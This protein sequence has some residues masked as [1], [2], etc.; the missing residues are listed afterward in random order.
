M[1]RL[2]GWPFNVALWQGQAPCLPA[3]TAAEPGHNGSM[4]ELAVQCA[5]FKDDTFQL[6]PKLKLKSLATFV[7]RGQNRR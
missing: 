7:H 5:R 2:A 6:V 4:S 3:G 1:V